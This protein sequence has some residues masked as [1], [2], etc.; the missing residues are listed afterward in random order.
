MTQTSLVHCKMG[1][2]LYESHTIID[3]SFSTIVQIISSS[4]SNIIWDHNLWTIIGEAK[5]NL[6]IFIYLLEPK[7]GCELV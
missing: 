7:E 2:K 4:L 6:R 1:Q 3:F 5:M